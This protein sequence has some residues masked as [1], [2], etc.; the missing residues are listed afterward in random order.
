VWRAGFG[1]GFRAPNLGELYYQLLH[2]EYGYQVIGNPT[3]KPETSQSF[4]TGGTFTQ[5]RFQMSLNL[6]RNNLKNLI[7]NVLI[8]DETSG[9]NCAGPALASLL[10]QYGVPGSFGYDTSGAAAFTFI[11]LNVDR[12]Y[13]QGFDVDGRVAIT[14]TLKFSGA[15]TYLEAVDSINHAW[16]PNRNRNQ[17][18]IKLEYAKA[19]WGL[20]ANIRG[21]FFSNWL[22]AAASDG[23]PADWAY[24]YAIWNLYTSKTLGHGLQ[25]FGAIDNLANSRDR[26]LEQNPPSYDRFDYGR[27][28]RIGMRF[29]LPHREHP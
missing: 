6:F 20:L 27:T 9:Q 8:C 11:N 25:A 18:H 28:F 4:S 21:T 17:G 19:R 24:G 3:L 14:P 12:A 2:L 26:K 23:S 16:L 13:T 15:Y 10:S 22:A 5:G 1:L 7:D 29:T